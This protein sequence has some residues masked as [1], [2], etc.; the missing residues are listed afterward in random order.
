MKWNSKKITEFLKIYEQY[1][2][3]W[4]KD[5]CNL[6]LKDT[7]FKQMCEELEAVN[8]LQ[9]MN[10]TQL[11]AKIKSVKDVC[12]QELGKIE[13]SK[14]SGSEEIYSPKLQWFDSASFFRGVLSTRC[15]QS[16]LVRVY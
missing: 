12:R 16:N 9:G 15:S 3:L 2:V 6:K 4:N 11:K 14:K 13:R 1:P 7:V 10:K 8:L 5:Y